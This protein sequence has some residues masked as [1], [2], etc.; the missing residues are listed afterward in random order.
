MT[1]LMLRLLQ[2]FVKIDFIN[3]SHWLIINYSLVSLGTLLVRTAPEE[4]HHRVIAAALRPP[5][6]WR[7]PVGR[8]RTT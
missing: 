8:M 2:I 6:D 3:T 4:D 7:R 5:A 1:L